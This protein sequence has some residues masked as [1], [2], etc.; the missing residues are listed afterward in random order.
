[1]SVYF[2]FALACD[3][4]PD[5]P[6]Q[7]LDTLSFMTRTEDYAFDTPPAG[8]LFGGETWRDMLR[9]S[10]TYFAGEAGAMFRKALRYVHGGAEV[11]RYTLSFRS[12]VLDDDMGEYGALIEWLA[13]YSDS[14]GFVGYFRAKYADHPT[15]LYFRHGKVY[16][17]EA[18]GVSEA[19]QTDV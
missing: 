14:E 6:Q 11:F 15:L 3:L 19:I 18:T 1:M 7:V 9:G 8:A 12:D 17:S 2:D 5:T 10:T 13:T 16:A 4:K